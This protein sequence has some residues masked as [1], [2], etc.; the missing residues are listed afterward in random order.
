M[1]KPVAFLLLMV[2]LFQAGI[3]YPLFFLRRAEIK[4]Q[5]R[6]MILNES[7]QAWQQAIVFIFIRQEWEQIHWLEKDREFC[8]EGRMF[9][10]ISIRKESPDRIRVLALEDNREMALYRELGQKHEIGKSYTGRT[11]L[12][13]LSS[14][15]ENPEVAKL[16]SILL[17]GEIIFGFRE[18][19]SSGPFSEVPAPPPWSA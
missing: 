5:V 8:H 3:Y 2:F 11:N 9:D 14:F 12:G 16:N 10:V 13:N 18:T 17:T 15:F 4:K 19:E 7:P 1:K 6:S